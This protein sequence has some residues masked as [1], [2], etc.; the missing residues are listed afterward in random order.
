MRHYSHDSDEVYHCGGLERARVYGPGGVTINTR[1]ARRTTALFVP[2]HNHPRYQ[3][4]E[5]VHSAANEA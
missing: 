2:A 4:P 1:V 3:A 5:S